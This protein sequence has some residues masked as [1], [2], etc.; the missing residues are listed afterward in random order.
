VKGERRLE[1]SYRYALGLVV[2]HVG[3]ASIGHDEYMQFLGKG[4]ESAYAWFSR[5]TPM[6]GFDALKQDLERNSQDFLVGSGD[7]IRDAA[8]T[9]GRQ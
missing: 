5:E 4:R 9:S 8:L 2:Y 6:A 1:F 3:N 7:S